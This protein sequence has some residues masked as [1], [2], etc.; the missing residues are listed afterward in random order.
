M[1]R[2]YLMSCSFPFRVC[3]DY[4]SSPVEPLPMYC[5]VCTRD[6]PIRT[7]IRTQ[8]TTGPTWLLGSL[9]FFGCVPRFVMLPLNL[10]D[11]RRCMVWL[12]ILV[13]GVVRGAGALELS[14]QANKVQ[15][16]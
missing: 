1:Q 16:L 6:D 10:S 8:S 14:G 5:S 3:P 12:A 13:R 7:K 11:L 4:S 15:K 2:E 9:S